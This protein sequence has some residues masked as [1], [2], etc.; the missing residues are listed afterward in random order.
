MGNLE[1]TDPSNGFKERT[2]EGPADDAP[3]DLRIS[4]LSPEAGRAVKDGEQLE[5]GRG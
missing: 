1:G 3:T 4:K 2:G 5:Q